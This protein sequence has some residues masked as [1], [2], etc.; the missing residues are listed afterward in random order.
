MIKSNKILRFYLHVT[1]Q[2]HNIIEKKLVLIFKHQYLLV[3]VVYAYNLSSGEPEEEGS[4]VQGHTHLEI[5][6]S[7]ETL[8]QKKNKN[9]SST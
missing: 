1:L 2:A 7:F 4:G 6:R 5:K 8:S 9:I 3:V